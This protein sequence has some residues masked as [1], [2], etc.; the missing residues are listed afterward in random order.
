MARASITKATQRRVAVAERKQIRAQKQD[1]VRASTQDSYVNAVLKLGLGADNPLSAST[2]G[3]NPITRV[4]TLLEWIY[5]GGWLGS[6]AVDLK[7]DDMTRA[8]IE[9]NSQ[10]PPEQIDLLHKAEIDLNF[11]GVANQTLKDSS[12]YGGAVM[13]ML[14][15]GQDMAAP[16]RIE[17]I[18]LLHG[19]LKG[20]LSLDRWQVEPSLHDLVS[21]YGPD[22]GLPRFY[23]VNSDAPAL[24]GKNIHYTRVLR[25]A[26]QDL[27]YWQRVQENLW[28]LSVFERIYDRMVGLD[29]ATQGAA[30]LV[31]KSFL[32]TYKMKGQTDLLSQGGDQGIATVM[33]KMD[34]TRRYQN[35]EGMTV[36]DSEDDI[37]TQVNGSFA[38]IADVILQLVQQVSGTLQIPL[39]RMYGQSPAGLNS[40]GESD[41]RTYYDGCKQEQ[42]RKL[43]RPFDRMYRAMAQSNSII[44]PPDFNWVF[45]SLWQ[46]DEGQK[47][48]I[49]AR[50]ASSIAEMREADLIDFST[51]MKELKQNSRTTGRFDNITDEAIAAA[52][53]EPDTLDL[54]GPLGLSDDEITEAGGD[55]TKIKHDN[56]NNVALTSQVAKSMGG[57]KTNGTTVPGKSPGSTAKPSKDAMMGGKSKPDYNEIYDPATG[58]SYGIYALSLVM[59]EKRRVEEETGKKMELRLPK[60]Q[61]AV[62]RTFDSL[63]AYH[64]AGVQVSIENMKDTM[65]RGKGWSVKMPADYGHIPCVDSAEGPMEWMDA[66]VGSDRDSERVWIIDALDPR[67]GKFDEHKCMLGFASVDEVRET[68]GDAYPDDATRRLGGVTEMDRESFQAWLRSGDHTRPVKKLRAVI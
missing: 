21:E 28:G 50:D 61:D 30:Q 67:T 7:A 8:G 38:G 22:I 45:K 39:V 25:L 12:L 3:F 37:T 2:Y 44:L 41:L 54:P 6:I 57:G 17:E 18:P 42:E 1:H 68:F 58:Q 4:R 46:L 60:S 51:A 63:P 33:K 9:I 56:P 53:L 55:P 14:I 10:I 52:A 36:I 20:F 31:Y 32:R 64:V 43:K 40:T 29:S 16:L 11:W 47:S 15:D 19:Q 27:P 24:R 5:R 62:R 59:K 26:G 49:S 13:V 23:K 48:E 35:N 65:R 34:M 66:F